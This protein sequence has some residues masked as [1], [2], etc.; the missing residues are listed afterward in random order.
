MWFNLFI[1]LWFVVQIDTMMCRKH[2][3]DEYIISENVCGR[4]AFVRGH[5]AFV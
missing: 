4:M 5:V 3:F 1:A 2:N